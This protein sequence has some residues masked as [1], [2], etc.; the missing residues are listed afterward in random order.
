VAGG[1]DR[2]GICSRGDFRRPASRR[3]VV[4]RLNGLEPECY[5]QVPRSGKKLKSR[6]G[7]Q[8]LKFEEGG[9][10]KIKDTVLVRSLHPSRAERTRL[11]SWQRRACPR[12]HRLCESLKTRTGPAVSFRALPVVGISGRPRAGS[13]IPLHEAARKWRR[14][15]RLYGYSSA[16]PNRIAC[17]TV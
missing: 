2:C 16:Y 10:G 14:S 4:R 3:W 7:L 17:S 8:K 9:W 11:S 15:E 13:S 1:A 12:K 5:R 6:S